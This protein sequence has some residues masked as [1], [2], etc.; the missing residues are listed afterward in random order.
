MK[1]LTNFSNVLI[2]IYNC[3]LLNL[4]APKGLPVNLSIGFFLF[5][6]SYVSYTNH[7][8]KSCENFLQAQFTCMFLT[9]FKK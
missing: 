9:Y 6:F 4:I 3:A 5:T 2:P 8:F 1:I 7:R